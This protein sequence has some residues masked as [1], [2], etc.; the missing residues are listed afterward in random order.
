M[1]DKVALSR[2]IMSNDFMSLTFLRIIFN[3]VVQDNIG[4][5]IF[6]RIF[7]KVFCFRNIG[8]ETFEKN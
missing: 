1:H 3:A 8:T 6:Y 7:T 5:Y 2:E 4:H